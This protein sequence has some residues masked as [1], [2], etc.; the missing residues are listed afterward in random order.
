[1][2]LA[3]MS[4]AQLKSLYKANAYIYQPCPA[5]TVCTRLVLMHAVP[6][7]FPALPSSHPYGAVGVHDLG[8]LCSHVHSATS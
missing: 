1:M 2:C 4:Q 8:L 6:A 3:Q 7:S 5:G